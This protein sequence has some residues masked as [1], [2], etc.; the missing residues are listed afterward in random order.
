VIATED[1][2]RATL[3]GPQPAAEVVIAYAGDEPVGFALFFHTFSTFLGKRGL[4]LEDLFV[5]PEWRGKG[6]GRAL[7]AHLAKIAA[8]RDCGRF[9]WAVLDWNEPAIGFYTSLGAKP[10][11]EWTVFRVTGDDLR[12]LSAG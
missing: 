10:M 11:H 5:L 4:Y 7:L 8:E 6:A 1:G 9:E 2:L 12:K 3:F